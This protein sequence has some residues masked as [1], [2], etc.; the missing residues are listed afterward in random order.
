MAG[1]GYLG[2]YLGSVWHPQ[3]LI[4]TLLFVLFYFAL[5]LALLRASYPEPMRQDRNPLSDHPVQAGKTGLLRRN[6]PL[7]RTNRPSG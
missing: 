2:M 5:A 6:L 4:T 7:G 3:G 1:V